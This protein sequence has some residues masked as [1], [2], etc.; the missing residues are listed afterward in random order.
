MNYGVFAVA[1]AYHDARGEDVSKL[2]F[3]ESVMRNH[4]SNC[5][6]ANYLSPFPLTTETVNRGKSS[7]MRACTDQALRNIDFLMLVSL[8]LDPDLASLHWC[9]RQDG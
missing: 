6:K 4:L 8:I 2:K 3:D 1:Y 9:S 5:Y 7:V